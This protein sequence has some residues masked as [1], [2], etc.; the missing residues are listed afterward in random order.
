[1]TYTRVIRTAV[2][3]ALIYSLYETGAEWQLVMAFTLLFLQLELLINY[4][5]RI[6]AQTADTIKYLLSNRPG[7][8]NMNKKR[9]QNE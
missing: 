1:M 9:G 4:T 3:A 8:K 5:N 7:V 2:E 6:A